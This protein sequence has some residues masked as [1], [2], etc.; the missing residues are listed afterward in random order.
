[1]EIYS[2]GKVSQFLGK[3]RLMKEPVMLFTQGKQYLDLSQ[4]ERMDK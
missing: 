4:V 1:M 2:N 3:E